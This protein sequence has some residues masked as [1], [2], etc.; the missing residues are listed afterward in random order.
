MKLN[1]LVVVKKVKKLVQEQVS[2][3]GLMVAKIHY[4]KEF[5]E[6]DSIMQDLLL[7]MQ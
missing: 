6:E 5:Q 3:H 7:D 4:T 1:E 2:S